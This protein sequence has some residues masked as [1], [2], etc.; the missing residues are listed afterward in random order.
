M[1]WISWTNCVLGL[2]LAVAPFTLD[3][4]GNRTA[5]WED[6]I[7]G[8][9]IAAF[10]FWRAVGPETAG[11]A[12]VSWTVAI[13]GL[14]ALFAP[15]LLAYSGIAA[16]TL[17]DVIVG[18]VVAALAAYRGLEKPHEAPMHTGERHHSAH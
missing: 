17:N 5:L 7:V 6:V 15:F 1:K 11:M 9:L 4:A 13:L 8:L 3:Y 12:G 16:A 10:A 2:W 18:V 14:W